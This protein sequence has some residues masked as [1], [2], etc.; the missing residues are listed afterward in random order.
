MWHHH[1]EKLF[2]VFQIPYILLVL[3]K[4]QDKI[5]SNSSDPCKT[6]FLGF[7]WPIVL[8]N[9]SPVNTL[10]ATIFQIA[11]LQNSKSKIDL[12]QRLKGILPYWGLNYKQL[13]ILLISDWKPCDF[14][15]IPFSCSWADRSFAQCSI[16]SLLRRGNFSLMDTEGENY[17]QILF[18]NRQ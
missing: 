11:H 3:Y 7:G 18:K 17:T 13:Q 10:L 16:R 12:S 6:G 8:H 2:S 14:N 5:Y 4:L 15:N 1:A 9:W